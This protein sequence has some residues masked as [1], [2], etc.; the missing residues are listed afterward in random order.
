MN[1]AIVTLILSIAVEVGIPPNFALAVALTENPEL[2]P[3]AVNVNEDGSRDLGLMQLNSSW[4]HGDWEHPET[5]I[6][7][8]CIHI[9][10]L[11][12]RVATQT[13][14]DVAIA[15]N[16]GYANFVTKKP[17]DDVLDYAAK[18]MNKYEE[19]NGKPVN[20]LIR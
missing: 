10:W 12:N 18:V 6:M 8:A 17:P 4:Y 15:Y 16:Y 13:L 20:P 11:M 5:N 2:N 9:K 1:V 19:L 3:K 14:W 7:A